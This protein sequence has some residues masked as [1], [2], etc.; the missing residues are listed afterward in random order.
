[1]PIYIVSKTIL[2]S[3]IQAN[4]EL[5]GQVSDA[6]LIGEQQTSKHLDFNAIMI[7][8]GFTIAITSRLQGYFIFDSHSRN[9]YDQ[10]EPSMEL[11]RL[12]ANLGYLPEFRTNFRGGK[13][14]P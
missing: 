10:L 4:E 5:F 6:F 8:K 9:A 1:M 11:Y 12:R 14:N 7:I 13:E 2:G 3:F